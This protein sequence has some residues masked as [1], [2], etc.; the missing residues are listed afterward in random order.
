MST[1]SSSGVLSRRSFLRWSQSMMAMFGVAPMLGSSIEASASTSSPHTAA[2]EDYYTK[3]GVKKMINAAGT[4]T[5]YTA[6]VMPPQVERAV[7]QAA[8]HP[9]HLKELQLKAGEYLA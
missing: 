7:A 6:A 5:I 2:G 4:Y 9:V 1:G 8:Q 3:L